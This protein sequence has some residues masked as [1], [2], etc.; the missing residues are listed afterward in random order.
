MAPD[1]WGIDDGYWDIAGGWHE[2]AEPTRRALRV[3]MGG[4]GDVADPPPATRPVWFVRHGQPAPIE[5]PAELVLEDG[6]RLQAT[7]LLPPDLPL[8]YH[9]LLPND[10]GPTTRLIVT[11]PRCALPEGLRTWG[12]S[13]QLYAARS[14]RS[15][16]IGDLGDLATLARWAA[17]QGAG[18]VGINPLHAATPTEHQ[19][20]S[21]YFPSSRRFRNP[22]YLCIDDVPGFDPSDPTMAAAQTT[23]RGL[24]GDRLIDRDAVFKLKLEVLDAL[25][26]TFEGDARFDAF[27]AAGGSSL[28]NFA[29]FCV[30]AE[31]HGGGWRD[32][33]SEYRRPDSPG[34]TRFAASH[35]DRIRFHCWLQWLLGDQLASAG[36]EIALL[37]DLAIGFDPDGAD[38]WMWQDVVANGVRV[39]APPDS[40]NADGQ[41]WGLPPFVPWKLRA[42]GYDPFVQTVRAALEHCGALRIDHV[43]GLFRL[44]WIPEDGTPADGTYVRFPATDLLDIVALESARS[45]AVIVGEDLG[46]VEDEM[47][48]HL[49]FRGVLSYRLVW[50]ENEPPE[51]FPEQAL[52]AVTTHD[53]PTIAGV[54]T[55][56]D[57]EAGHGL[58][59][60][61]E[62]LTG[63]P[64]DAR[65]ED[66]VVRSHARLADAPSMIVMATLDDALRICERP[67][68]PGTTTERPNWS[69][70]LTSPLEDLMEDPV[71]VNVA[72]ALQRQGE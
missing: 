70:A 72:D 11:P 31:R 22:L 68:L 44:F 12:W 30:L 27:V 24:N 28:R 62:E 55:H 58:H 36:T 6:T 61:L 1:A 25:W 8:G 50:F 57:E 2:T 47:R 64:P 59:E 4:L 7:N 29:T 54:W 32:W 71:T 9:D 13:A 35:H 38:A 42:V 26:T 5:R 56:R 23:G 67:N 15:W 18:V 45:G 17:R 10:G 39:G 52:A 69:L 20:P 63:L 34:I 51:E 60:R 37:G 53:L 16:G 41:D 43:M 66:V 3:A 49:S 33:P 21:P 46:T 48:D 40:F 14:S 65:V 19:E